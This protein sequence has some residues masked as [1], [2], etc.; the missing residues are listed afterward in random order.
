MRKARTRKPSLTAASNGVQATQASLQKTKRPTRALKTVTD[1]VG[2]G[3][4]GKVPTGDVRMTA[5]IRS[6]L[7]IKL[8]IAA[9]KRRTTIGELIEELVEKNL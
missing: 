6:D 7:H 3:P 8:K 1:T 2:S 9:A 5:N 4:S